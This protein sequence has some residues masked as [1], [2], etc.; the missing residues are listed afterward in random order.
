MADW[1]INMPTLILRSSVSWDWELAPSSLLT[2]VLI[3]QP[4][5]ISARAALTQI[6]YKYLIEF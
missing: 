5:L 4:S 1:C 3:Y 6:F 2:N